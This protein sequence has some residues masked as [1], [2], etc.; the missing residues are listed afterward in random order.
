M[1]NKSTFN[2]ASTAS[3][4]PLLFALLLGESVD[5]VHDTMHAVVTRGAHRKELQF[6]QTLRIATASGPSGLW[7]C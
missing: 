5:A 6:I 1:F 2:F 4:P 7:K 3:A